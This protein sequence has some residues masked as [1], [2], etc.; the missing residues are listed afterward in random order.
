MVDLKGKDILDGAQFT[1]EE[2]EHIMAVADG[3]RAQLERA[4]GLDLLKGY[5]MGALFF[6]P[7]THAHSWVE[8]YFPRYGWVEFEPT[9]SRPLIERPK[10]VA[11]LAA[12]PTPSA[13]AEGNN[14]PRP[15]RQRP[16]LEDPD[17][18]GVTGAARRP[19][20]AWVWVLGA[21]AAFLAGLFAAMLIFE[22]RGLGGLSRT[23]QM[24]ARLLRFAGW[25]HVRWND[26][27]TPHE[28]GL[29]FAGAAPDASHLILQ[30]TD[31]YTC[32]Q[33]GL[34]PPIS[35]G[36]EKAWRELSPRLWLAGLR[37]R[38]NRLRQRVYWWRRSWDAFTT[39]MNRQFG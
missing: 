9:T 26:S 2:I 36:A 14:T 20:G 23:A 27:Q 8:V 4:R 15:P 3:F 22:R 37:L 29:A 38:A 24:Y 7:S 30:V 21:V 6:E 13:D 34:T 17:L 10:P 35:E 28:R 1:R 11:T 25:L 32:E 5:V 33:Y 39:R 18:G 12:S 19:L 31:N 16:E